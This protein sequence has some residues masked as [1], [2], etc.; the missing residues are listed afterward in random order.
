MEFVNIKLSPRGQLEV[1]SKREVSQLLDTSLGGLYHLYRNCSLA[2]LNSGAQT[3]DARQLLENFQSFDIKLLQ[4]DRGITIELI[5][6]PATAFVEGRILNGIRQ[7]LFSVL[8]DILYV[9]SHLA[10]PA[11]A[12]ESVTNAV[13]DILRNADV[14]KTDSAPKMVVCWGGH[15]ILRSEYEYTK[16]VGY[17]LGLRG[18]DICTGCG[19]GA[20]KGPMKGAAIGHAKQRNKTGRYLGISEPGIIAAEPP[21]PIINELVIM[22]DIEKRLEAFV[23]VGHAIVVF[24]GG[25]GTVEE[26]LYLIGILL[27]P[28]N[29]GMPFPLVFAGPET[30]RDYFQ[31]IDTFL[32]ATLGKSVR[33]YYQIIIGEPARVANLILK[34]IRKVRKYRK[35]QDDAY[36]YNWLLKIPEDMQTP[37][38]P[39]HEN[40]AALDLSLDQPAAVLVANLRRAF[41]GIVAG[42]I[43]EQGIL[44]IEE[45][46]PFQLHGDPQLLQMIDHMLVSFIDQQRMRLPLSDYHACYEIV[47]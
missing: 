16:E 31:Q 3:D 47:A 42:N 12:G 5:D 40:L 29:Q 10:I 6:A 37:F 43:K 35:A 45:K 4:Q 18:L 38:V 17:E 36:Y 39:S 46:G 30:A 9:N 13:F 14:L 23:R 11:E 7:L 8:R 41:S 34:G 44:T 1:L 33:N 26:I 20:M 19:D 27:H 32:T 28:D 15:S 21:N 22:P 24:P 2:V 25:A